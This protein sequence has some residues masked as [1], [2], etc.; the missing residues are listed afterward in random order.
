MRIDTVSTEV[1]TF[2]ELTA[3]SQQKAIENCREYMVDY[4]QWHDPIIED[5]NDQLKS[6]GFNEVEIS[7]NGFNS[8]GD[9]ASFV[10]K[11][12]NLWTLIK[13]QKWA[14][15]YKLLKKLIDEGKLTG[16]VDRE[17]SH[18]YHSKT[19]SCT[20]EVYDCT[21]KQST[22]VNEFEKELDNLVEELSNGIYK[23][24]ENYYF[25]LQSDENVRMDLTDSGYEFTIEGDIY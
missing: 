23:D 7:Y 16:S 14:S 1:F 8:Q 24:L 25:E 15:K 10:S 6:M 11:S 17:T 3:K 20:L 19:V 9:G 13:N 22:Q 12:I 4:D 2:E 21:E 5:W 18:Y